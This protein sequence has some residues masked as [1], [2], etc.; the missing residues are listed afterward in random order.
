MPDS[1]Q[2]L[3]STPPFSAFPALLLD[4]LAAA[5]ETQ[6]LADGAVL[7]SAGDAADALY[8]VAEGTLR[9]VQPDTPERL[10][11]ELRP[12]MLAGEVQILTGGT[13]VTTV[14]A[15]GGARVVRL[16]RHAIDTLTADDRQAAAGLNASI[17]QRLRRDRLASMLAQLF[18]ALTPQQLDDIIAAGSWITLPQ[19][20]IL[21][22]QG[23]PSE[24]FDILVDGLLGVSVQT[25]G[26]TTLVNRMHSGEVV[27]EIALL[28]D[29]HRAA[30]VFAVRESTLVQFSRET[31][32]ALA[33]RYPQFL[34][35][36]AR[37]NIDRLR[38]AQGTLRDEPATA[39]VGLIPLSPGVP[40]V[41]LARLLTRELSDYCGV[42]HVDAAAT[43]QHLGWSGA[44]QAP[45]DSPFA[46][47]FVAWL[48]S[49]HGRHRIVLLE[50]EASD[51]NWTRRCIRHSDQLLMVAL[52]GDNPE[53]GALEALMEPARDGGVP[54]RLLLLHPAETTHPRHTSRW[55]I[56]RRLEMHHHVRTGNRSDLRRLARFLN[57][58]AMGLALGGGG[59]RA[60]AQI[61]ALRAF[62]DS[63]VAIDM[64]AGTSMGAVM[65]A[66]YAF[67]VPPD[68]MAALNRD[69]FQKS[70]LLLDLTLPLLSFTTG[71]P[72]V[73]KLQKVFGDLSSEDLWIPFVCLSSNISRA[74]MVMHRT[75]VLWRNLRAT[76]SVQGLFPPVIIDGELHVDGALFSNLP[77]DV[78]K[79]L[80]VGRVIGVDVTPPVDLVRNSE[81]GDT[82]SG[83]WILWH[84]L[85]DRRQSFQIADIG[86]V[87]QRAAEAASMANQ[88]QVIEKAADFYLR[89]PVEH[90]GL[91]DFSAL[92]ELARIGYESAMK[93]LPAW[94]NSPRWVRS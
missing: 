93:A 9:E 81:Y 77:A 50:G 44:A 29:D 80:G 71:K 26:Q 75:G 62:H 48:A 70:G 14:R 58:S 91:L 43:D 22:R 64:I 83:W 55:L 24:S 59:A 57:G 76:S 7:F 60:F 89:M 88:K 5:A 84:R 18:G 30:T 63:G 53:P 45:A 94:T 34:L 52:A 78:L 17:R 28:T 47:K 6:S 38:R 35:R 11:A 27:G 32:F 74:Q 49:H 61:G 1:R 82:V 69:M 21:M 15:V 56:P 67:G 25:D 51:S 72:Y 20:A 12:N 92:D 4:R 13:R 79:T 33:H 2:I 42:L 36:I 10:I 40:I 19:G 90:I 46:E 87:L 23:E 37:L 3:A 16:A 8:V 65:G 68:Q 39:T 66:E 86:T 41:E 31:F 85:F 54:Q 73:G